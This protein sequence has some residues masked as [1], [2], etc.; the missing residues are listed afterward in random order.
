MTT[1]RIVSVENRTLRSRRTHQVLYNLSYN[2][3]RVLVYTVRYGRVSQQ[4]NQV[5][6]S[7]SSL[8]ARVC[9]AKLSTFCDPNTDHL[10]V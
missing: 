1:Q 2:G 9:I 10:F 3:W 6:M 7:Q 4:A 8:H 5:S